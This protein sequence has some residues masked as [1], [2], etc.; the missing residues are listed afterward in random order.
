MVLVLILIVLLHFEDQ[1]RRVVLKLPLTI[2]LILLLIAFGDGLLLRRPGESD[3]TTSPGIVRQGA[4]APEHVRA[5]IHVRLGGRMPPALTALVRFPRAVLPL[6]G[7]SS[8][9]GFSLGA[10]SQR[11]TR[12]HFACGFEILHLVS[13]LQS[14]ASRTRTVPTIA[15]GQTV[16]TAHGHYSTAPPVKIDR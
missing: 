2:V 9:L 6:H 7:L 10:H 5:A 11:L 1:D 4:P 3:S 15:V 12:R 16:V 13:C 14:T 8:A